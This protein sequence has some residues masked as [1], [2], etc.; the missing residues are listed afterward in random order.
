MIAEWPPEVLQSN[1]RNRLTEHCVESTFDCYG[2]VLHS[3]L[4]PGLGLSRATLKHVKVQ[5]EEGAT[6]LHYTVGLAEMDYE[7][8][9]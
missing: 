8:D 3:A 6:T 5:Q 9:G 2:I 4:L 1:G 7:S